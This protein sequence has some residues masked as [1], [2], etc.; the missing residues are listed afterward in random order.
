MHLLP[1]PLGGVILEQRL[2]RWLS[3]LRAALPSTQQTL[4]THLAS[5]DIEK[6]NYLKLF[7]SHNGEK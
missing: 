7:F 4:G 5:V 6:K 2:G 1:Q 3:E